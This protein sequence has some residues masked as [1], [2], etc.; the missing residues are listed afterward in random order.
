METLDRVNREQQL[1]IDQNEFL[2]K[3]VNE[4]QNEVNATNFK[5]SLFKEKYAKLADSITELNTSTKKR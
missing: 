2:E 5:F 3:N 1:I 4:L